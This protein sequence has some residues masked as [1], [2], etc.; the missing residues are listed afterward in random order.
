M[1]SVYDLIGRAK[2][3]LVA[4]K[5]YAGKML[6]WKT[7]LASWSFAWGIAAGAGVDNAWVRAAVSPDS[8]SPEADRV[9]VH[10][11]ACQGRR[12]GHAEWRPAGS[13]LAPRACRAVE[14]EL[15]PAAGRKPVDPGPLDPLKVDP[16]HYRVEI[17]NRQVRV[18]RA[19]YGAGETGAEHEHARDRVTVFLTDADL[20]VILPDGKKETLRRKAHEFGWGSVSRHKEINRGRT[21]FEVIAVEL[22]LR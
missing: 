8:V 13:P 17:E 11:A 7:L 18:L 4:R 21:P 12:A 9:A 19:R 2:T 14:I 6:M 3:E 1:S 15:K 10:L 22:K 20:E 16:A 5:W